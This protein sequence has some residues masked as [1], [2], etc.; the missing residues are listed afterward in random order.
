MVEQPRAY[1]RAAVA[2]PAMP[3][4]M[5]AMSYLTAFESGRSARSGMR[6]A[7]ATRVNA[8][9]RRMQSPG[10]TDTTKEGYNVIASRRLWYF[11]TITCPGGSAIGCSPEVWSAERLIFT[12]DRVGSISG[13]YL[14]EAHQGRSNTLPCV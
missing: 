5:M 12:R 11:W 13:E 9:Q 7:P 14:L 4:P 10:A 3:A 1:R 8:E 6:H 2:I